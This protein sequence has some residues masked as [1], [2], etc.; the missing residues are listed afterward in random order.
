MGKFRYRMQNILDLKL[1][2]E[3][4]AKMEYAEQRK[5][6]TEAEQKEQELRDQK[7]DYM[8][9]AV[10]L[11]Q[12]KLNILDIK[13]NVGALNTM[14]ILI[15]KQVE[16]VRQEEEQLEERRARLEN[17]MKER[18][19]QEKLR[20]KAFER[21]MHE[22]NAAESKMIDELTSYTYGNRRKE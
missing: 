19:A 22:E 6:L 11:R 20:E 7:D 5:R 3:E 21:Y 9:E 14:D 18:K 4:Q 2:L 10:R 16:V 13:G 1:K 8:D 15:E 12:D 17:V